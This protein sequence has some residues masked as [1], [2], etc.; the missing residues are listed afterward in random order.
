MLAEIQ[1]IEGQM[2]PVVEGEAVVGRPVVR[3]AGQPV[4]AVAEPALHL[5]HMGAGMDG[6]GIAR[7]QLQRPPRALL[8][9]AI[10][11]HLLEAEGVHAQ[12]VAV[13]GHGLVPV[14][15]RA[16]DAVAQLRGL[17]EIEVAEMGQLQGQAV[18]RILDGDVA[19]A[20]DRLLEVAVQ[21]GAG[22]G[23]VPA[24]AIV[25]VDSQRL[26]GLDALAQHRLGAP[27]RWWSS[28]GRRGSSGP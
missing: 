4:H 7:V 5:H 15:E 25:G 14:A 27:C 24:L 9:A 12:N 23:Q 26:A 17:A 10:V 2:P 1:V 8:G 19:V 11:A 16:G 20:R 22:S 6:P 13:A 28:A 21:P 18:A 3:P